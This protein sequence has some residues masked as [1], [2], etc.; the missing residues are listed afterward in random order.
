VVLDAEYLNLL[1]RASDAY[2]KVDMPQ[3]VISPVTLPTE[4]HLVIAVAYALDVGDHCLVG[5]TI[6]SLAGR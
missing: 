2:L 5:H 1:D 4:E 3:K 6:S